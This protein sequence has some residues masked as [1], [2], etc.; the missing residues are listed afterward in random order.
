VQDSGLHERFASN[1][2]EETG[3]DLRGQ[4]FDPFYVADLTGGS[5]IELDDNQLVITIW[6]PGQGERVVRKT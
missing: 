4:K 2:F 5:S 6:K 3:F 1:L